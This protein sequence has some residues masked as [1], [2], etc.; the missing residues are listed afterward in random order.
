MEELRQTEVMIFV[1]HFP[2][3]SIVWEV[4]ETTYASWS[5]VHLNREIYFMGQTDGKIYM[6]SEPMMMRRD[7][8]IEWCDVR[9]NTFNSYTVVEIK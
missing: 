3:H 9:D 7:K 6:G 1:H 4:Y 2:T 8:A 5:A